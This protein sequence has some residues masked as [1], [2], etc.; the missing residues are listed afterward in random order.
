MDRIRAALGEERV[1]YHGV[2]YGTYLGAVYAQFPPAH[3]PV[4]AGQRGGSGQGL[5]WHVPPAGAWHGVAIPGFRGV[6]RGQAREV[7]PGPHTPA[8]VRK[9]WFRMV[10]RL[11]DA[12][13]NGINRRDH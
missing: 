9:T 11:D 10:A 13:V 5:A 7:R 3:G 12:P 4:R 2:S 6:G 8:Q 1:S